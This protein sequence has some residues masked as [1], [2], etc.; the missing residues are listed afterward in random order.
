[1]CRVLLP[2][3]S[4]IHKRENCWI[5][6]P[7]FSHK[8]LA[9]N[10]GT[11]RNVIKDFYNLPHPPGSEPI[12]MF[13]VLCI[14]IIQVLVVS[15]VTCFLLILC[16]NK[17]WLHSQLFTFIFHNAAAHSQTELFNWV[18]VWGW[19]ITLERGWVLGLISKCSWSGLN[20]PKS[21]FGATIGDTERKLLNQ[22]LDNFKCQRHINTK[23]F[24]VTEGVP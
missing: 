10:L 19:S 2:P 6:L 16:Y 8:L 5:M 18:A 22:I 23:G 3:Q 17:L 12:I 21:S 7:F 1:M 13:F 20:E 4:I 9:F 14:C 15:L 24:G 11:I